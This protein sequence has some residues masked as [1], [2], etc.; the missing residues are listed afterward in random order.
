MYPDL[1]ERPRNVDDYC[2]KHPQICPE[3][4]SSLVIPKHGYHTNFSNEVSQM[5]QQLLL[6]RTDDFPLTMI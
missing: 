4:I 5:S 2:R 6:N 3:D 1:C